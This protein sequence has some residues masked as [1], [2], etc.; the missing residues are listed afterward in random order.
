MKFICL[1]NISD[2][3]F[4]TKCVVVFFIVKSES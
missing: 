1:S 2:F 3:T 4:V